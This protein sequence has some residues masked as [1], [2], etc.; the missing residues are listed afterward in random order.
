MWNIPQDLN[1]IRT[2]FKLPFC[3]FIILLLF[4]SKYITLQFFSVKGRENGLPLLNQPKHTCRRGRTMT[5]D[6]NECITLNHNPFSLIIFVKKCNNKRAT[7]EVN[8][9]CF[10]PLLNQNKVFIRQ[11]LCKHLKIQ[12]LFV[13]YSQKQHTAIYFDTKCGTS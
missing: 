2:S 6:A 9:I 4:N 11:H 7:T 10:M 12:S 13:T 1:L 3:F 5:H 8:Y